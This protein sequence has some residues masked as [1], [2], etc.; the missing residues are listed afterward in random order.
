MDQKTDTLRQRSGDR[1]LG[2]VE[3]GDNIPPELLCR[4]RRKSCV[5]IA[6]H[7]EQGA[8]DVVRLQPVGFDQCAQQL[9]GSGKDLIRI[10]AIHCGGSPNTVEANGWSHET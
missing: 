1:Y 7:R 5:K 3:K 6:G 9:V 4:A 2:G 8:H 10:V